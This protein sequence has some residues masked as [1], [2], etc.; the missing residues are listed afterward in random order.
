MAVIVRTK[1]E[2]DTAV[3]DKVSGIIVKGELAEKLHRT[4]KI[5]TASKATIA[6]LATALAAAPFTGGLS[7]VAAAP[8]AVLT[9]FEIALILAV[10]FLG[11]ALV[12]A[13]WKTM[14]L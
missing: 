7:I 5:A 2:L 1:E 4:K 8:I 11:V 13:V 14:T 6:L 10:I 3:K 12:L 9:G